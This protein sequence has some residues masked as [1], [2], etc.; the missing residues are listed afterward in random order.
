MSQGKHAVYTGPPGQDPTELFMICEGPP[1]DHE[2]FVTE[3]H[4]TGVSKERA[5]VHRDGDW[6]RSVDVWVSFPSTNQLLLQKRSA[7]KDTWPN[8]WDVS[9]AGSD[10]SMETAVREVEEELGLTSDQ[11]RNL[12][13]L[14]TAVYQGQSSSTPGHG[15]IF[16]NEFQDVY[17]LPLS[18]PT[19]M[20]K[21]R[22]GASEVEAVK[23]VT[24]PELQ[25]LLQ[26]T[27]GVDLQLLQEDDRDL[28]NKELEDLKALVPRS[29]AYWKRFFRELEAFLSRTKTKVRGTSALLDKKAE[30]AC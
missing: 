13:L 21:L 28:K 18:D 8:C 7:H 15:P 24:V 14:F 12:V 17:L 10:T 6:H 22:L 11:T 16:D 1:A 20:H 29:A 9:A 5:L 23:A 19:V 4:T 25:W 2:G 26:E 30:A 3:V 27:G